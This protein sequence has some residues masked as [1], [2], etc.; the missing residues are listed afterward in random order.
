MKGDGTTGGPTGPD[1][2]VRGPDRAAGTEP[3]GP[4]G[5]AG[6]GPGTGPAPDTS[7]SGVGGPPVNPRMFDGAVAAVAVLAGA[8]GR[9]LYTNSAFTRLFGPRPIGRPAR[10]AFPDSDAHRFLAVVDSVRVTGR[11]R[12]VVGERRTDTGAPGQARHFVYSCSPV[13]TDHGP[14]ILVLAMDTTAET[15]TLQRYEALVSAVSQ[16]VWVLG[17][18]G[19]MHEIVPGWEQLTGE[20]WHPRADAD[21]YRQ[22]HPRDREKLSAAWQRAAGGDR[23]RVFEATFR[24]RAADG[25]YRHLTTRSV[26]VL[27]DGSLVEWVSATADVEDAWGTQLRE[28]LLG[29]VAAVSGVSLHE[30]FAEVVKVVVP[31]LTDA[32]LIML[33]SHEE[34]PLPDHAEVTARRIAS[35]TRPGLPAPPALRGQRVAVPPAVRAVLDRR[36]PVTF[37]LEPGAPMPSGL[38]PT[39]SERWLHAS[40]A[41]SLTLIPL[42]VGDLVLGYAATSSNG[43]TP[44]PGPAETEL[45]REVLHHAQHPI[46]KV[47]ELQQARRTAL[48]LQRAHLT[49]PPSVRGGTLAARYQPAS[50]SGEIGGDWYD[51]FTHPDGTLV[52]GIGDVAGHDLTAAT[53]MGQ[54][55]S[56]LRALAYAGGP[57]ARPDAVLAR[58]DHVSAGL[59]T[60]PLATALHVV[61]RHRPDG[62]WLMTW[63]SAG[64]PPPLVVPDRG[65]AA[66]LPGAAD[67]PLCVASDLL[68]TTHTHVL[69]PGDTLLLYT[70]GLIETPSAPIDEGQRRL[71]A[72]ATLCRRQA[73][74]DLLRILQG[75]S[76]HRDDTALLAFRVDEES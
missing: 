56:M 7:G 19:S 57:G 24:V 43:D 69:G 53:A 60:A 28:R 13:T 50:P 30:A 35:A 1:P 73:L 2:A 21:W 9:L 61:L 64:H 59:G 41:T 68:R 75:L 25:S 38:I 70:D 31:E 74:P 36:E 49:R 54:M 63:S 23:P 44:I 47:V 4:R 29:Q 72:E 14:G 71:A 66:Y 18:D 51:A 76:D 5:D 22:I 62:T 32:C 11:A 27:R 48:G 20:P 42:I 16:M 3:G 67:P 17:T 58:L 39:V 37:R 26:P 6:V 12:Q 34:W 10:E 65:D 40:G 46:R 55:R 8:E 15:L 45:L 33:L 52:L